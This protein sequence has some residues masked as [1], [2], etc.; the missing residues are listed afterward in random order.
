MR[1]PGRRAQLQVELFRLPISFVADHS[2][3]LWAGSPRPAEARSAQRRR[4]QFVRIQEFAFNSSACMSR[5]VDSRLIHTS[6]LL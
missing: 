6:A 5:F 1:K 4:L 3:V 2:T